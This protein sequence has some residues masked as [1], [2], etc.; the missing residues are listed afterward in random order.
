MCK[1]DFPFLFFYVAILDIFL[2]PLEGWITWRGEIGGPRSTCPMHLDENPRSMRTPRSVIQTMIQTRQKGFAV[3]KTS[4]IDL[5][6]DALL[7]EWTS[8][9]VAICC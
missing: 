1:K 2:L 5:T 3:M 4:S 7:S 9:K 8:C 6:S